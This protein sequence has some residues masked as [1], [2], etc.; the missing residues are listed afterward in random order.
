MEI[1]ENAPG[2]I[3]QQEVTRGTD[4]ETGH[5]PKSD[6]DGIPLPPDDDAPLEEDMSDVDAADSVASEHPDN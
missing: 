6:E 1:N 2:N 5:D 3:S 4:N